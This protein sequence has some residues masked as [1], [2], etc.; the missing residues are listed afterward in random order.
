MK[1]HLLTKINAMKQRLLT[2]ENIHIQGKAMSNGW[3]SSKAWIYT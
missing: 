3:I 1:Q 2:M